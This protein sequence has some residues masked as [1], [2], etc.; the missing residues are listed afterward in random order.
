[1]KHHPLAFSL[2]LLCVAVGTPSLTAQPKSPHLWNKGSFHDHEPTP[3]LHISAHRVYEVAVAYIRQ[4]PAMHRCN[5][6]SIQ[7]LRLEITASGIVHR[8]EIVSSQRDLLLLGGER[9]SLIVWGFSRAGAIA[10]C[11]IYLSVHGP[12]KGGSPIA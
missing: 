5:P 3:S 4:S 6:S 10:P 2:I 1:M 7:Y 8:S 11:R 12:R 9:S